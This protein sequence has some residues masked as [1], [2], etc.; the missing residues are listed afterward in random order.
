[1]GTSK[2]LPGYSSVYI[3]IACYS[4]YAMPHISLKNIILEE[5]NKMLDQCTS[6][7]DLKTY[8]RMMRQIFLCFIQ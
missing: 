4:T 2:S 1:M 5:G 6:V 7:W 8:L 3:H